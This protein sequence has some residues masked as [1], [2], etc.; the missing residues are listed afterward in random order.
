MIGYWG[1]RHGIRKR[2]GRCCSTFTIW[3]GC[4]PRKLG[5]RI[6]ICHEKL[7]HPGVPPPKPRKEVKRTISLAARE[8]A[9][10]NEVSQSPMSWPFHLITSRTCRMPLWVQFWSRIQSR[11]VFCGRIEGKAG[12]RCFPTNRDRRTVFGTVRLPGGVSPIG[13]LTDGQ[14]RTGTRNPRRSVGDGQTP[15]P[16]RHSGDDNPC[17]RVEIIWQSVLGVDLW[18]Q[19]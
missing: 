11:I 7:L 16:H 3:L 13:Y 19:C 14:L 10:L 12:N 8:I 9:Y 2:S 18:I 17:P 5:D 4:G 15:F 1:E 6:G